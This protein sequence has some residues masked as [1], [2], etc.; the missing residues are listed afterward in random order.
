MEM[1]TSGDMAISLHSPRDSARQLIVNVRFVD[2]VETPFVP[3]IVKLY[4]PL[5][6]AL[7]VEICKVEL[8]PEVTGLGAKLALTPLG[9]LEML[10]VTEVEDVYP[11]GIATGTGTLLLEPRFTASDSDAGLV[12]GA[13]TVTVTFTEC[14]MPPPVPVTVSVYGPVG[15]EAEGL[16]VS[17]ELPGGVTGL[18][19]V[20]N[21]QLAF[22]GQLL[23]LSPT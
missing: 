3:L 22:A 16:M 7:F 19:P 12:N 15:V 13:A 23:T 1:A 18:V 17:T 2:C 21:V 20:L 10:S 9:S 14:V 5:L 4:V 6:D 8:L 11:P